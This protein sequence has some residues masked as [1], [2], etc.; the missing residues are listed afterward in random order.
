MDPKNWFIIIPAELGSISSPTNPLKNQG[1][2]FFIAQMII[3]IF[4]LF[5]R[6]DFFH[7]STIDFPDL[8]S[9]LQTAS[10]RA[11]HFHSLIGH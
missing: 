4:H 1:P 5:Q 8:L 6:A 2:Y 9:I 10:S 3:Q 11:S 7:K